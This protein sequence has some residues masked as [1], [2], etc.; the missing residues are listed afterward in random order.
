MLVTLFGTAERNDVFR[1]SHWS[2]LM[3]TTLAV[4]NESGSVIV[5]CQALLK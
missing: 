4:H 3:Q 2:R 1:R 5:C